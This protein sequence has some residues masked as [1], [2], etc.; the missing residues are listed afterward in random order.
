MG[1]I[2]INQLDYM[3]VKEMQELHENEIII[4]NEVDQLARECVEGTR[5][6]KELANKLGEY[7]AHVKKHFAIEE[8][9]MQKY[10]FPS[11]DMHQMSHEMFLAD[12]QYATKHWKENGD[13]NKIVSFVRKSPEWIESHVDSV[14]AP[15]ADY[16]AKKIEAS[17]K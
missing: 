6:I 9:L 16:I 10:D 7:V 1:I 14:D 2:N 15:T 12:L 4:I 5:D 11:Y 13:L 3:S 17:D 8:E